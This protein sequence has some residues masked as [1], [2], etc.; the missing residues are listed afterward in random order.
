MNLELEELFRRFILSTP[1]TRL[2]GDKENRYNDYCF[3]YTGQSG[4]V[5]LFPQKIQYDD[6]S[7][8]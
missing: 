4:E 5:Y 7:G 8:W 1:D 3:S 2:I 6:G